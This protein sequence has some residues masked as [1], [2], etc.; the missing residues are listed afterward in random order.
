MTF[1]LDANGLAKQVVFMAQRSNKSS[2]RDARKDAQ[3]VQRAKNVWL[4][5][6]GTMTAIGGLMYMLDGTPGTRGDGVTLPALVA[7][8]GPS[9]LESIF[10]LPPEI[11]QNRWKSIVIH[12]TGSPYATADSL[13][14]QAKQMKLK[15][16]G[17]H[18]V[19]GNGNG[20]DDGELHVG[21]RWVKQYPGAHSAGKEADWYNNN[22][23]GICLVGNGDRG[24]FTDA[25]IRRL[26][27]LVDTLC[28]ELG[29]PRENVKLHSQIAP[30]S[31]PGRF[32]PAA[33]FR[34]RL[35]GQ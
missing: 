18:F 23:L 2:Q 33:Q 1:P 35:V 22:A 4:A 27:Q 10:K 32:F 5:L 16:L 26:M 8:A 24:T 21:Y 30:T 7:S 25:Q 6:L 13:D 19:I 17:Y 15:G 34:E 11:R 20:L 28:S 9:S 29:V 14:E 3:Q 31:S 12:H